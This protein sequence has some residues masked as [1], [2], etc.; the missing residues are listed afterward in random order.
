MFVDEAQDFYNEDA[1]SFTLHRRN[2]NYEEEISL[3]LGDDTELNLVGIMK[4]DVTGNWSSRSSEA[5][6]VDQSHFVEIATQI[7][8]TVEQWHVEEII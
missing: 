8:T 3:E 4:G 1:G 5:Q 2:V 6:Y 7:N